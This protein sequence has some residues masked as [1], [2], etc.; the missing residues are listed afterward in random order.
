MSGIRANETRSGRATA[1]LLTAICGI[2]LS[3]CCPHEETDRDTYLCAKQKTE[4]KK[5]NLATINACV[6]KRS[7]TRKVTAYCFRKRLLLLTPLH[8]KLLRRIHVSYTPPTPLTPYT[9][10]NYHKTGIT[11]N[12][13]NNEIHYIIPQVMVLLCY[14][15]LVSPC[16]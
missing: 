11:Y 6:E 1:L 10:T 14:S 3:P 8:Y 4:K 16:C 7:M 13:R 5:E 2:L 12:N 15:K 9:T